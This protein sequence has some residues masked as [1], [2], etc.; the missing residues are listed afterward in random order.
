MVFSPVV[1]GML[2]GGSGGATRKARQGEGRKNLL[3][4]KKKKQ[5]NFFHMAPG[6]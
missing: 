4:L 5:K 6:R 2:R 1:G 3:F